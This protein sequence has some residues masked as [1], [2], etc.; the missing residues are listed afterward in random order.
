M[1]LKPG[2]RKALPRMPMVQIKE[3]RTVRV[4]KAPFRVVGTVISTA[5]LALH[6]VGKGV[7][8][9]GKAVKMGS[10][11]EWVLE[12]DVDTNGK[13][14]DWTKETR[15]D[16]KINRKE[17]EKPKTTANEKNEKIWDDAASDAS[18]EAEPEVFDEKAKEFL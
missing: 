2:D 5:G 16:T 10:S 7:S 12:A 4:I 11:S 14:I 3:K 9:V 13:K 8:K 15:H 6:Q 18:T 1:S 17:V